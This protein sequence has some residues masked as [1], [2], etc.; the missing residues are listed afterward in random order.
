MIEFESKLTNKS[1]SQR[2]T[3]LRQITDLFLAH[4]GNCPDEH[5]AICDELMCRLMDKI[6]REAL[7]EQIGRAH[8]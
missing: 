6:E 4:A 7:I 5:V 1:S 8:V 2:F 3:I